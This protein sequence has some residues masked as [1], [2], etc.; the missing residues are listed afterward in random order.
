VLTWRRSRGDVLGGLD[1]DHA[2]RFEQRIAVDTERHCGF[3]TV[4]QPQHL[5]ARV[6]QK[7]AAGAT[8]TIAASSSIRGAIPRAR[9]RRCSAHE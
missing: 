7:E 5:F 4:E 8:V 2:R 1:Q 6:P 3:I 9:A